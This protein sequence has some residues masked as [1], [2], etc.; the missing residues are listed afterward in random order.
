MLLSIV[1]PSASN[2][3]T[4]T[5]QLFVLITILLGVWCVAPEAMFF[6]LIFRFRAKEGVPSQYI[7]GNKNVKR[8]VTWPH[9]LI[10]VCDIIIIIA[11]VQLWVRVKQTLPTADLTVRVRAQ[12]WTWIFTD[13][14]PD[15]VLDTADDV[16]TT[17]EVHL[18]VNKR[19]HFLLESK[20]V[21]H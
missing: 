6:W 9:F 15:G 16:R 21:L 17:D 8:W 2:F 19:Y 3:A 13:P 11:A 1:P 12:Q 5:D 18:L 20:D 14:G 4:Q 10:L 7:E